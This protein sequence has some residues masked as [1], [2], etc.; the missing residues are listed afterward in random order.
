[1]LVYIP[2][3]PDIL[4]K[5]AE[6]AWKVKAS[7]FKS[8][9]GNKIHDSLATFLPGYLGRKATL[10]TL[11]DTCSVLQARVQPQSSSALH[12]QTKFPRPPSDLVFDPLAFCQS[13][14]AYMYSSTAACLTSLP[15]Q[16]SEDRTKVGTS[17]G[18]LML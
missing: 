5:G 6:V 10:H 4:D 8:L 13:I 16:L 15:F 2:D 9:E 3:T 1:M 17:S 12:Q 18:G 14:L 11:V 7:R